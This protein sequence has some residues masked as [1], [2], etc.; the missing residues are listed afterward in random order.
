MPITH[1]SYTS[2]L[3]FPWFS[4]APNGDL[5][6][7]GISHV[8]MA[9]VAA[10]NL[11]SSL[12]QMDESSSQLLVFCHFLWCGL[13]WKVCELQWGHSLKLRLT[14]KRLTEAVCSLC[15]PHSKFHLEEASR[16]QIVCHTSCLDKI[17]KNEMGY[18][19]ASS[20]L[21]RVRTPFTT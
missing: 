13:S 2:R 11:L 9:E 16:H 18:L 12:S 15:C 21:T 19:Q 3:R 1:V 8:K 14:L 7:S 4:T 5:L 6:T 10:P 20:D 17:G